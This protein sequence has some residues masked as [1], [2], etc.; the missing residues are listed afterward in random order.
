VLKLGE[1]SDGEGSLAAKTGKVL[2]L[3]A[4]EGTTVVFP[5]VLKEIKDDL[6]EVQRRLAHKK[7]GRLTQT[8]QQGVE[9]NL[10]DLIAALQREMGRRKKGGGGGGGGG[11]GKPPL[12][13]PEAELRMLRT[14][15]K[16]IYNRTLVLDAST[17]KGELAEPEVKHQHQVVAERQ[18]A[19]EDMTGQLREKLRKKDRSKRVAR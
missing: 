12:V 13:P 3:V 10:K 9:S 14:R 5:V 18:K 7:A 6:G 4:G 11:G 2:K 8:M 17:R 1:L 19:L 15:Q 16:Q